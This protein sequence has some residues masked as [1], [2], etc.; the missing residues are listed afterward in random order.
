MTDKG[1]SD[2]V[3]KRPRLVLFVDGLA[4]AFAS[5]AS[6]FVDLVLG[7]PTEPI[8]TI[9]AASGNMRAGSPAI[10]V[11]RPKFGGKPIRCL[12]TDKGCKI[13]ITKLLLAC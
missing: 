3:A 1:E 2:P 9:D 13:G 6:V 7:G 5:P 4:A 8:G 12:W 10:A 11:E